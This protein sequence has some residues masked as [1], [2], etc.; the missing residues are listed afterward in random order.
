MVACQTNLR[1]AKLIP[2]PFTQIFI[3]SQKINPSFTPI[4]STNTQ[5]NN[6]FLPNPGLNPNVHFSPNF[7]HAFQNLQQQQQNIPPAPQFQ[8]RNNVPNFQKQFKPD[9]LLHSFNITEFR[10]WKQQY[11]CY[12]YSLNLHNCDPVI[13]FSAIFINIDDKLANDMPSNN[14]TFN[15]NENFSMEQEIIPSHMQILTHHF[16]STNPLN[17]RRAKIIAFEEKP[18]QKESEYIQAFHAKIIDADLHVASAEEIFAQLC[19]SKLQNQHVRR[20]LISRRQTPNF[21]QILEYEVDKEAAMERFQNSGNS[22]NSILSLPLMFKRQPT[23]LAGAGD[24]DEEEA[25]LT[26]CLETKISKI[27]VTILLTTCKANKINQFHHQTDHTSVAVVVLI[28]NI[29]TK[30]VHFS[31][32]NARY[33]T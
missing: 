10:H 26:N 19:L 4:S 1:S 24:V 5:E 21:K 13:Q 28:S 7:A 20:E 9:K 16:E 31:I 6:Q 25:E 23:I 18:G 17:I 2:T 22:N 29:A 8:Q 33:A 12:F 30:A 11:A 14:T 3:Q 15:A 32:P 27:Q